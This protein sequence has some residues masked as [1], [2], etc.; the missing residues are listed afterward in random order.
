MARC[1]ST[2]D[3]ATESASPERNTTIT[4]GRRRKTR[5]SPSRGHGAGAAGLRAA[6]VR[7]ATSVTAADTSASAPP[8]AS[9]ERQPR[10]RQRADEAAEREARLLDAHGETASVRRKPLEHRFARGGVEHAET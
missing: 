3:C 5:S 9:A 2:E 8:A 4:P 6:G 1:A 7:Y 10:Q